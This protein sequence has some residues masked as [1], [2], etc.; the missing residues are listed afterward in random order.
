MRLVFTRFN[1]HF[2]R[3]KLNLRVRY[4]AEFKAV[5]EI[6]LAALNVR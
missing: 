3:S 5:G 2:S 6:C 4:P 1:R